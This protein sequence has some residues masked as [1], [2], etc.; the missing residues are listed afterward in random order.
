MIDCITRMIK[1]LLTALRSVSAALAIS[2]SIYYSLTTVI[3]EAAADVYQSTAGVAVIL[4]CLKF[5][6]TNGHN[7]D[8]HYGVLYSNFVLCICMLYAIGVSIAFCRNEY[9]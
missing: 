5:V 6:T 8:N 2:S 4:Y 3:T 9:C 1:I 7:V